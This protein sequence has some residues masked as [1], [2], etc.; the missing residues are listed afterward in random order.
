MKITT[1]T[2]SQPEP[3][4][5]PPHPTLSLND[6][7][8]S[9]VEETFLGTLLLADSLPDNLGGLLARLEVQ[10]FHNEEH[11]LLYNAIKDV[12][13]KSGKIVAADVIK[14]LRNVISSGKVSVHLFSKLANIIPFNDDLN[15]L[16]L[17][18]KKQAAIR[19]L[20]KTLEEQSQKLDNCINPLA[21]ISECQD[22]LETGKNTFIQITKTFA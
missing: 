7:S 2:K 16:A 8:E 1:K 18:I 13:K 14:L 11:Q 20:G 17:N 22:V 4:S 9:Y 21:W 3:T 5:L 15:I 12:Q 10:D 6:F 19:R